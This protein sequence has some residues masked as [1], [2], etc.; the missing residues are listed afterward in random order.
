M[1]KKQTT[2]KKTAVKQPGESPK[3]F[4]KKISGEKAKLA[5]QQKELKA[6]EENIRKL[7]RQ[8]ELDI[9]KFST[10]LFNDTQTLLRKLRDKDPAFAELLNVVLVEPLEA[11]IDDH[12]YTFSKYTYAFVSASI[13]WNESKNALVNERY[14]CPIITLE[15]RWAREEMK[16]NLNEAIEGTIAKEKY[17][18]RAAHHTDANYESLA[19]LIA[20]FYRRKGTISEAI[21]KAK[22]E[23]EKY[24]TGKSKIY[25][26]E[27]YEYL[28]DMS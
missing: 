16:K 28:Y 8:R 7:E 27:L 4:K 21:A 22:K 19:T 2:T 26:N 10:E 25:G 18:I 12:W 20:F 14:S 9:R 1:A 13:Q 5:A 3:E 11:E 6:Q 17:F 15:F 24:R 23:F